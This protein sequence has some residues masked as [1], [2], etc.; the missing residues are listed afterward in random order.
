[1]LRHP[2]GCAP[3][4]GTR[5]GIFSVI[6]NHACP[7]VLN[8]GILGLGF[9]IAG[10]EVE[11]LGIGFFQIGG[12]MFVIKAKRRKFFHGCHGHNSKHQTGRNGLNRQ[13]RVKIAGFA[14]QHLACQR[15]F[16]M[17]A[18][19]NRVA[20]RHLAK[21]SAI[22]NSAIVI[23]ETYGNFP[24]A[25]IQNDLVGVPLSV[26]KGGCS[27]GGMSGKLQ[28]LRHGKDADFHAVLLLC[29]RIARNDKGGFRKVG[30]TRQ[31]LHFGIAQAA[32]LREDGKLVSLKRPLCEDIQRNKRQCAHDEYPLDNKHT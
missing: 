14:L 1:M 19:K 22:V 3:G 2:R 10:N 16:R 11:K 27:Q 29:R 8:V 26:N 5:G 32:C 15:L 24:H 23:G 13:L 21:N 28:L 20:L 25:Q 30:L 18:P 12:C 31:G 17:D 4:R 7:E 6:K 9:R